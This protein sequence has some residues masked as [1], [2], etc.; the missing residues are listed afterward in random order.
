MEA[1]A[2]TTLETALADAGLLLVEL[3]K[4]RAAHD[5]AGD[6]LR[7]TALALGSRARRQHRAGALGDAAAASLL[8][9]VLALLDRLRERLRSI[10]Q[11][12][13]FRRAIA[14]HRGGDLPVLAATLPAIFAGLRHVTDPPPLFHAVTWLRRSRPRAATDVVADVLH[15][16]DQGLPAEGAADAPGTDPEL[17]AV[18]LATDEPLADPVVLRF[19]PEALPGAVYRLEDTGAHLVHV[20]CLRAPFEVLVPRA[21][22]PDELGEISL[23]HGRYRRALLDAL[24]D[25]G[26]PARD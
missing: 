19:A 7:A 13:D 26:L 16:R 21:L 23:D 25:A 8:A 15:A 5:A 14:A 20:P 12:A 4:F 1:P 22:D 2:G 6:D 24:T 9:E 18:A 11:G 3:D 10:R 17:P